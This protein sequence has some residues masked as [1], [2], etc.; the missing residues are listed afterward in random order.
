MK[1]HAEHLSIAGRALLDRRQFLSNSATALGSIALIAHTVVEGKVTNVGLRLADSDTE[2]P[3]SR[4]ERVK[5]WM[6]NL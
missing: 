2:K 6:K 5:N 4:I 3:H 1:H